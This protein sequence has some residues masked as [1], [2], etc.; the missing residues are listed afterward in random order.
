MVTHLE[1]QVAKLTA[2][3][4]SM[5]ELTDE[6]DPLGAR[7]RH[8]VSATMPDD[9]SPDIRM[10]IEHIFNTMG[11]TRKSQLKTTNSHQRM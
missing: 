8:P 3:N 11:C 4:K 10:T 7:K 9:S 2:E 6:S 1:A 5:Q